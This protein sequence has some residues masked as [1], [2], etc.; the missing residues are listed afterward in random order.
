MATPL[1]PEGQRRG[2]TVPER[3]NRE[4]HSVKKIKRYV[5]TALKV[6]LI[7]NLAD[8]WVERKEGTPNKMGT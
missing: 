8:V 3:G 6:G 1:W 4:K 5:Q 7:F 2:G